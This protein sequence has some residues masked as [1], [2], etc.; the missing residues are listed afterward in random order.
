MANPGDLAG[1]EVEINIDGITNSNK[2]SALFCA[3]GCNNLAVTYDADIDIAAALYVQFLVS[4]SRTAAVFWPI[5]LPS[6]PQVNN[7]NWD[8][9]LYP[10]R[11]VITANTTKGAFFVP[12]LWPF[13]RIQVSTDQGADAGILLNIRHAIS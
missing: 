10:N 1:S 5:C 13:Y 3:S 6:N 8:Y 7:N 4:F 9:Q 12:M 11:F 2:R